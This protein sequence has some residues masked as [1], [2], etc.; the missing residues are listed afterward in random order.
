MLRYLLVFRKKI[1][2][3]NNWL[4]KKIWCKKNEWVLIRGA[5]W[6]WGGR[7]KEEGGLQYERAKG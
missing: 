1:D 7:A 4:N 2:N 3:K 5:G 6:E